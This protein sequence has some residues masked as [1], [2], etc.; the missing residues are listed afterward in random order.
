MI[1]EMCPDAKPLRRLH[2]RESSQA[3]RTNI[4]SGPRSHEPFERGQVMNLLPYSTLQDLGFP[5]IQH[6]ISS[7][8]KVADPLPF[9]LHVSVP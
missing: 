8:P 7:R 2:F 1:S 4:L 3:L 9:T 5:T 6:Q